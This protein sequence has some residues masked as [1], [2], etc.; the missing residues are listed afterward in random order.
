M[1]IFSARLARQEDR[2][3]G[4]W[5]CQ[6]VEPCSLQ[7]ASRAGGI[8]YY[9]VIVIAV[10]LWHFEEKRGGCHSTLYLHNC[11]TSAGGDVCVAWGS[12]VKIVGKEALEAERPRALQGKF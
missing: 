7:N 10:T 3:N 9:A 8:W 12:G 5:N 1:H 11:C 2:A 4:K 6:R